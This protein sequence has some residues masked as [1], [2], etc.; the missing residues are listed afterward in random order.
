MK[1]VY[2]ILLVILISSCGGTRKVVDYTVIST[3]VEIHKTES[4]HY[5]DLKDKETTNTTLQTL[6]TK[7]TEE[8]RA[9]SD[10]IER[11]YTDVSILLSQVGKLP[12]IIRIINDIQDYQVSLLEIVQD[13]P[14]FVLIGINT[15]VALMKRVT[16]LY[17]YVYLNAILGTDLNKMPIA[18]RLE[19]VDHVLT[20]LR[21]IRGLCYSISSKMKNAVRGKGLRIILREYDLDMLYEGIDKAEIIRR[22]L[23]IRQ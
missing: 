15:E 14:E 9:I 8:Y 10:K 4:G 7:T 22:S 20:E 19:I 13:H 17:K 1:F 5:R 18:K 11:R 23:P 12:E 21:V 3:M 2:I 6:V 16:R